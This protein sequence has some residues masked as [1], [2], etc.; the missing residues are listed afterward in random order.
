MRKSEPSGAGPAPKVLSVEGVRKT[1]GA[2]VAVDG[3]TFDVRRGEI[4]GLLGPN[5][6]GKTTTINMILGVL[7]PS[8]GAVYIEGMDVRRERSRALGLTNFAAVYAPLPG[9][10]TVR[11]SLRVFGMIYG[12]AR[13]PARIEELLDEFDLRPFGDAKCGVLSSGEQTRVALAKAMLNRPRLLLLDEPTASLDPATA[14]DIRARIREF[15]ARDGGGVLWTS[16]NMYEV[17]EVCDRVLFLS[18][19][20]I[21]L[22]GDPRQL[23]G[24]HGLE[25]LE[26]LFMAVAREPL[27]LQSDRR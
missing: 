17:E 19:G 15:T 12:V 3:V 9:N 6:A 18:R 14:R 13:L 23:P 26:E 22:A 5:G 27:A 1:Y 4:V 20:R 8:A 25:T 10:L 2:T 21:L 7:E 24:E 16:H 11:Q